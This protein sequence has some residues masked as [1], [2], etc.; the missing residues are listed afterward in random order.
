MIR[1]RFFLPLGLLALASFGAAQTLSYSV[2]G[3]VTNTELSGT[4][5]SP[6]ADEFAAGTPIEL[7]FSY[8]PS[9]PVAEQFDAFGAA[10]DAPFA[11]T[12]RIGGRAFSANASLIQVVDDVADLGTGT[13][14]TTGDAFQFRIDPQFED[15]EITDQT[16]T[17]ANPFTNSTQRLEFFYVQFGKTGGTA[18]TGTALPSTLDFS[19]FDNNNFFFSYFDGTSDQTIVNGS[20]SSVTPVPEPA[21]MLALGLGGLALL[22]RR[23]AAK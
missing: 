17:E 4:T 9:A 11:V 18:F 1:S 8:D 15:P 6:I 19:Q 7:S 3:S 14:A 2:T 12:G 10:Y 21:S 16:I 23:R 20:V 22:R 13:S 5:T